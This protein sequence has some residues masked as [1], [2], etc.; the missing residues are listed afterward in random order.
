MKPGE[1]WSCGLL[2]DPSPW[3]YLVLEADS[4]GVDLVLLDSAGEPECEPGDQ[5]ALSWDDVKHDDGSE[6]QLSWQLVSG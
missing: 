2:G 4:D 3:Y 1:V 5:V 6:G